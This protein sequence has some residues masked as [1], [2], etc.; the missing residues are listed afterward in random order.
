MYTH[1]CTTYLLH[2][3]VLQVFDAGGMDSHHIWEWGT[4][5][6]NQTGWQ[7]WYEHVLPLK[8][9]EQGLEGVCTA[10]Q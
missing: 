4:D 10:C 7:H 3:K 2:L 1:A 9:V 8:R 5:K 6:V